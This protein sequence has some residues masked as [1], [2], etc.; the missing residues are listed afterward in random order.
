MKT[1]VKRL[2]DAA[3]LLCYQTF[4][5]PLCTATLQHFRLPPRCWAAFSAPESFAMPVGPPFIGPTDKKWPCNSES[6]RDNSDLQP[7]AVERLDC[8]LAGRNGRRKW[9]IHNL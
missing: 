7:R 4:P 2:R 5:A 6:H 8:C 3:S 9:W 1:E